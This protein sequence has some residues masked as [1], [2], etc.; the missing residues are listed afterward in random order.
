M[1]L[2]KS[3]SFI[4]FTKNIENYFDIMDIFVLPTDKESF[5][6]VLIEA[7]AKGKPVIATNQ[8]G[9][10]EI[11]VENRNGYLIEPK[12]FIELSEKLSSLISDQELRIKMGQESKIIT[13][14]KFD[15][16]VT[17]DNYIRLFNRVIN[18]S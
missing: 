12:N 13:N 17:I 11:I 2:K 4:G 9:P 3:I 14:E 18:S 10:K 6:Y 15:V 16:N 1:G 7:M 8:G 5:G